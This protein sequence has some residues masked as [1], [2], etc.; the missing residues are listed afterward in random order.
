MATSRYWQISSQI[1]E[2]EIGTVDFANSLRLI[3]P[4]LNK[5]ERESKEKATTPTVRKEQQLLSS[6]QRSNSF[7]PAKGVFALVVTR[8]QRRI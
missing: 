5:S 4:A 7:G 8:N 1:L 2:V 3:S 6:K